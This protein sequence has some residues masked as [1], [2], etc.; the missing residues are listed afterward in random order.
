MAK[1]KLVDTWYYDV[2]DLEVYDASPRHRIDEDD[3]EDDAQELKK[4]IITKKVEIE[5]RMDKKTEDAG[6]P[7]YAVK[8]IKFIVSCK[9]PKF[10]YEG[11]DIECL[12][13][14]A[15]SHLDKRFEVTWHNYFLVTVNIARDYGTGTSTGL[16]FS[17]KDIEKGVTWDG[18]ELLREYMWRGERTISPWPGKF[19]DKNGKA[20]ACIPASKSNEAALKEFANRVDTLRAMIR[21]TLRPEKIVETLQ[22][23]SDLRLL[24]QSSEQ[25]DEQ[26]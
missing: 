15:F 16:S 6:G 4:R 22:N 13:M 9:D 17:Y 2:K 20:I 26:K 23:M 18:K 1:N 25:S 3:S 5:V 12:R 24:P 21:D 14:A 8:E 10:D 7:P 19:E 11:T